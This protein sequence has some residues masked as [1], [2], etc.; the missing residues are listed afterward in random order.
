VFPVCK[1]ETLQELSLPTIRDEH[2]EMKFHCVVVYWECLYDDWVMEK[3]LLSA[4]NLTCSRGGRVLFSGLNF[5]LDAGQVVQLVG[6]NGVGKTSLLRVLTGVLSPDEGDVL[7]CGKSIR[8]CLSG[9]YEDICYV[10]H[11]QGVKFNLTVWENLLFSTSDNNAEPR[12]SSAIKAFGLSDYAFSYAGDLSQGQRQRVA[13][14]KL[15]ITSAR[16]WLL[17]EPFAALDQAS[18]LSL[19]KMFR[20]KIKNGGAVLLSTHHRIADNNLPLRTLELNEIP[21]VAN[22]TA[23]LN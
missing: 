9:F 10:G 15:L 19:Q 20:D 14:A 4:Q 11:R 1:Q 17:D 21:A 3:C 5:S 16:I 8:N 18:I 12:I 23:F 7:W 13:L 2:S 6:P 22:G